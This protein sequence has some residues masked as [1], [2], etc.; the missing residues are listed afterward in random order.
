[1]KTRSAF[2]FKSMIVNKLASA[3]YNDIQGGLQ[4]YESTLNMSIEQ[5]EDEVV[6]E[7]LAVIKKYSL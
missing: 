4:G 6:E 5:L 2:S 3:I 1:V 7:R